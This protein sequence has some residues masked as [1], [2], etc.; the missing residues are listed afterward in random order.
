V[1]AELTIASVSMTVMSSSTAFKTKGV[2]ASFKGIFIDLKSKGV[3]GI[4]R[5]ANNFPRAT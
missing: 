1:L 2:I 3:L 4:I 5:Q